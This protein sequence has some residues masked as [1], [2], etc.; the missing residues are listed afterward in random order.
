MTSTSAA[1]HPGD[2]VDPYLAQRL[3]LDELFDLSLYTGFHQHA[4]GQLQSTLAQLMVVERRHLDFWQDLFG[5]RAERLDLGRRLQLGFML[6]VCRVLGEGA[7][8]LALEAI[9]VHGIQKY[10]GLWERFQGAPLAAAIR[11]VLVDEFEHEDAIVSEFSARQVRPERVRNVLL[12]FNDG[13]V[14]MVGAVSG[15]FA[16]FQ[17]ASLVLLASASVAVAGGLSMA[18]GAF[19]ASSSEAEVLDTQ[20]KKQRFLGET[21]GEKTDVAERA[22]ISGAIVGISY[23]VGALV[24]TTPILLGAASLWASVIAGTVAVILVSAILSFLSGMALRRR[25]GINLLLACVSV[26]ATYAIG[27]LAK[28]L[29]GVGV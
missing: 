12:G 11:P 8:H 20:A 24:P 13:L 4:S 2:V 21:G 28:N 29:W 10:L 19:A 5:V 9:E 3:V 18:A 15:F 6:L 27:T 22:S 25:V 26:V 23:V 7:V 17:D 14:E 16:S 1:A